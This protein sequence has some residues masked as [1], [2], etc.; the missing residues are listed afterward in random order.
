MIKFCIVSFLLQV[1][2]KGNWRVLPQA[3]LLK[4]TTH[5]TYLQARWEMS[6]SVLPRSLRVPRQS[7]SSFTKYHR[8][9]LENIIAAVKTLNINANDRKL[10]QALAT[11][12]IWRHW[13][14][15]LIGYKPK[16]S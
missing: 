7:V 1:A 10:L 3:G 13:F 14:W 11:K 5:S 12:L 2:E 4:K 9:A 6:G 8:I 15:I 16:P